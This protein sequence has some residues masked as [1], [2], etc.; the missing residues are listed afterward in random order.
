[1]FD[2]RCNSWEFWSGEGLF[3]VVAVRRPCPWI[4]S[5]VGGGPEADVPFIAA[6]CL[7]RKPPGATGVLG[8]FT[9]IGC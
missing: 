4:G 7:W 6:D 1:M 9:G 5:G 2:A 8:P 3:G